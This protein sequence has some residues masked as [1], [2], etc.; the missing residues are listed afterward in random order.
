MKV[1]NLLEVIKDSRIM[2]ESFSYEIAEKTKLISEM[3]GHTK[4]YVKI[5]DDVISHATLDSDIYTLFGGTV[6][7]QTLLERFLD[8]H[9]DWQD[10][11]MNLTAFYKQEKAVLFNTDPFHY[12]VWIPVEN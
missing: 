9:S 5:G 7:H 6:Q 12:S 4:G 11:G 2:R 3:I 1:L 8:D 10:I